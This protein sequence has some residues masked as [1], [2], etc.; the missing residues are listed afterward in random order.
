MSEQKERLK[1]VTRVY[2]R[3]LLYTRVVNLSYFLRRVL[4]EKSVLRSF[5]PLCTIAGLAWLIILCRW[6]CTGTMYLYMIFTLA[7]IRTS[8][9]WIVHA[10]KRQLF[11][12]CHCS[13]VYVFCVKAWRSLISSERTPFTNLCL[14]NS[15]L[16]L[17]FSEITTT[18][19]LCPHPPEMSFI[20]L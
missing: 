20:S 1:V 19:K 2:N 7:Y 10:I 4:K 3:I 17:N 6:Y 15:D 16:S 11:I 18:S 14:S 12:F 5:V 8:L 13:G 9:I